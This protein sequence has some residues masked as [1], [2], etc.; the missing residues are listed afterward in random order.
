MPDC[1]DVVPFIELPTH[2]A[3][4]HADCWG[5]GRWGVGIETCLG[6]IEILDEYMGWRPKLVN[7]GPDGNFVVICILF[8]HF[9]QDGNFVFGSGHCDVVQVRAFHAFAEMPVTVSIRSNT[10]VVVQ[11]PTVMTERISQWDDAEDAF[12]HQCQ[13]SDVKGAHIFLRQQVENVI[14]KGDMSIHVSFE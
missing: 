14:K 4:E 8:P 7:F 10:Q 3:T 11:G 6:K 5:D 13:S 2:F 9:G 1:L 12:K